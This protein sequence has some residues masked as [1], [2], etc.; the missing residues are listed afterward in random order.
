MGHFVWHDVIT[1]HVEAA[2]ENRRI[3]H[4]NQMIV[5]SFI[6]QVWM[7]PARGGLDKRKGLEKRE[8]YGNSGTFRY[9]SLR[10]Y[11]SDLCS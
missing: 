8:V 9:K 3:D 7:S 4:L 1:L 10:G 11:F 2:L 6:N 5:W